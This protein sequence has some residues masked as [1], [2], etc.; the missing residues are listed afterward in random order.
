MYIQGKIINRCL[1]TSFSINIH[2]NALLGDK[3]Q[4]EEIKKQFCHCANHN[5]L[6][7]T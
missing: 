2:G 5:L 1:A 4:S 3:V 6:T 7:Q